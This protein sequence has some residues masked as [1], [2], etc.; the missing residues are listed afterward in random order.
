MV[1]QLSSASLSVLS[2]SN[3]SDLW[4]SSLDSVTVF[5]SALSFLSS[6]ASLLSWYAVCLWDSGISGAAIIISPLSPIFSLCSKMKRSSSFGSFSSLTLVQMQNMWAPSL[7]FF[8]S[9]S[10]G[11]E[12]WHCRAPSIQTFCPLVKKKIVWVFL[13]VY[14]LQEYTQHN[15]SGP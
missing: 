13:V 4:R 7:H 5:F 14:G 10:H 12:D 1:S 6:S 8:Q 15:T 3:F 11:R 2:V 9:L